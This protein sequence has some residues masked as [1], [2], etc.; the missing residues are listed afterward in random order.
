MLRGVLRWGL[1]EPQNTLAKH[2]SERFWALQAPGVHGRG[3]AALRPSNCRPKGALP[4]DLVIW[5]ACCIHATLVPMAMEE[6]TTR[7]R[8]ITLGAAMGFSKDKD[9]FTIIKVGW[10]L[11][12]W[13]RS[14][15]AHPAEWLSK[16]GCRGVSPWK[17]EERQSSLNVLQSAPRKSTSRAPQED[18]C[19]AQLVEK[20]RHLFL[21]L[22][23]DFD[24][25][26]CMALLTNFDVF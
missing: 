23:D 9:G 6:D 5:S 20:C 15:L 16:P 3:I 14:D 19:C 24:F 26:P 1:R 2:S 25:L 18:W 17:T 10:S 22:L 7:D 11:R 12:Q 13:G 8:T 4:S 21:I